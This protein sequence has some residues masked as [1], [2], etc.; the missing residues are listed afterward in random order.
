MRQIVA[1]LKLFFY[2][3]ILIYLFEIY[4]YLTFKVKLYDH[5][6]KTDEIFCCFFVVARRQQQQ[7]QAKNAY[8]TVNKGILIDCV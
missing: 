8:V 2:L 5:F 4:N 1:P 7:K 6:F 3:I